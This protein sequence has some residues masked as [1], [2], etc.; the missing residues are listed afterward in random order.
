VSVG[1]SAGLAFY[2]DHG[3][4]L[5][6]LLSGAD[7]AMYRAKQ[8]PDHLALYAMLEDRRPGSG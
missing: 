5:E 7:Q 1:F 6:A 2:P 8:T 4:T 3:K